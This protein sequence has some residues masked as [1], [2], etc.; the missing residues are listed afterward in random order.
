[1]VSFAGPA[2]SA[3]VA[4]CCGEAASATMRVTQPSIAAAITV[5]A[6][7]DTKHFVI[8]QASKFAVFK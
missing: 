2:F 1:M 3:P 7:V 8:F 5:A 6:I 4:V